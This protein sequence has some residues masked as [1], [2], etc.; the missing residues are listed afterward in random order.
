MYTLNGTKKE[1]LHLF[2]HPQGIHDMEAGLS[3]VILGINKKTKK[4]VVNDDEEN[5]LL[6]APTRSG[7]GVNTI[8]PTGLIWQDSIFFFDPKGE[9]W[10][11]TA[12]Y[13]KKHFQQ[14]VMMFYPRCA[15]GCSV[16]WNPLAEVRFGTKEEWE[17][18][19]ALAQLLLTAHKHDEETNSKQLEVAE[20]LLAAVM[21]HLLYKHHLN[22]SSLP[23]L[24]DVSEIFQASE[25]DTVLKGMGV[26]GHI[27]ISELLK[28]RVFR[29]LYGEYIHNLQP[30]MK[31]LGTTKLATVDDILDTIQEKEKF[32]DWRL[33]YDESPYI[34]LATHPKVMESIQDFLNEEDAEKQVILSMIKEALEIYR[35][36]DIRKNMEHSDFM[37]RDLLEQ[38]QKISF[39]FVTGAYSDVC[40]IGNLFVSMLLREAGL[41]TIGKGHSGSKSHLLIMLDEFDWL[42]HLPNLESFLA[43]SGYAGVKVCI[44]AMSIRE[45][46]KL[47]GENTS[48]FGNCGVQLYFTP[49]LEDGG[50]T[51]RKL[52]ELAGDNKESSDEL[53]KI[54][55]QE[56]LIIEHGMSPI[57]VKKFRY[58]L[59]KKCND[60]TKSGC[61]RKSDFGTQ[62]YGFVYS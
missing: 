13:R 10:A 61:P 39:Y 48:I 45:V 59:N 49:T 62:V 18:A 6:I 21:M 47:Y 1:P 17:D 31:V 24:F 22:H 9:L 4:L 28:E 32:S 23:S 42:Q 43:V 19:K 51:Q 34:M 58:Y 53:L 29:N 35:D 12:G 3:G 52:A 41:E 60:M 50:A 56:G 33:P 26:Y 54:P 46:T 57:R 7:K 27:G 16:S 25:M 44:V 40:P 36:V 30:F 11:N 14:K 38:K 2:D 5:V 15:D 37:L 20:T 55:R 8:I